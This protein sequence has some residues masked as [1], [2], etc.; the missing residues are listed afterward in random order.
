M[1]YNAFHRVNINN[2]LMLT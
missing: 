1:H 2:V